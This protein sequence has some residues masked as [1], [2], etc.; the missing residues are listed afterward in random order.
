M[1]PLQAETARSQTTSPKLP[2]ANVADVVESRLVDSRQLIR[3][4]ERVEQME[5]SKFEWRPLLG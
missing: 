2:T 1:K 3:H 4:W 5:V